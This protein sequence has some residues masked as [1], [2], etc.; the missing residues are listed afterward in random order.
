MD[1]G[2]TGW[3]DKPANRQR[4]RWLLYGV[5]AGLVVVDFIVHR[6]ISTAVEEVPAF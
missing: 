5:C 2:D 1:T 3:A 4:V 6:H